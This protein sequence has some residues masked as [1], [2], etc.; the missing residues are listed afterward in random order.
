MEPYDEAQITGEDTIIR[1]INPQQHIVWDENRGRFRISSK[2]FSPSSEPNG[3]M[4]VDIERLM[5]ADG[6]DPR[7]Y[8]TTPV[9][10]GSVAFSAG[11]ARALGLIVGYDPIPTNPYHGEVWGADRPNRFSRQQRKG[12]AVASRWYV[13][14]DD[15]DVA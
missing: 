12:L 5:L 3:G 1:R 9:F 10:T 6:L 14:L 7:E 15:V 8:V 11:A 4:S 2:V 13:E